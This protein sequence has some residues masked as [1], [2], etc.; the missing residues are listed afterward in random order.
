M[1]AEAEAK[2]PWPNSMKDDAAAAPL[3][4][5]KDSHTVV[6]LLAEIARPEGNRGEQ[7]R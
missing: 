2:Q 3:V 7:L 1:S 4:Q 6:V 5:G